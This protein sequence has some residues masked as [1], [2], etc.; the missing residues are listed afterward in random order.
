MAIYEFER[1]PD[2]K[3]IADISE[4]KG[5]YLIDIRTFYQADG[6]WRPT[7]KGINIPVEKLPELENAVA[8][9]KEASENLPPI[10]EEPAE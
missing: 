9:I 1:N 2:E 6:E 10:V 7:K 5:R 4:F 3:I 8:K